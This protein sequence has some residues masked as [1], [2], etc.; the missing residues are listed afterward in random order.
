MATAAI[1]SMFAVCGMVNIGAAVANPAVQFVAMTGIR[2]PE[3][4]LNFS[5]TDM[6]S[7]MKAFNRKDDVVSIP[8]LVGKNLEA[9]VYY[10][11]YRW[12]RQ[13]D[14]LP[15]EWTPEE[16]ARIEDI[17]MQQIK[18]SKADRIGE[19]MDPGPIDVGAGYHD[20]VGRF[21]NKLHSMIGAADVPIIYIIRPLH[22]DDP[23]WQPDQNN[24]T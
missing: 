2:T 14:I 6:A 11:K 23:T 16:M 10:A 18:V 20:W 17:V 3:D 21:Q 22:D 4:L 12:H 9:L 8:M 24:L 7:I 13:L 15:A 5:E 1:R 19:N